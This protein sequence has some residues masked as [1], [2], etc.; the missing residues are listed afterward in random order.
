MLLKKDQLNIW[1]WVR[2]EIEG[3]IQFSV[4]TDNKL[5]QEKAE[6]LREIARYAKEK[7]KKLQREER[8]Y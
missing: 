8:C 2:K 3:Y 1:R 5:M 4:V 6:I 7:I